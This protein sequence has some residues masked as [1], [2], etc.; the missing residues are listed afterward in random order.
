MDIRLPIPSN[1]AYKQ[2][3]F[4]KI[5]FC[6]ID[7]HTINLYVSITTQILSNKSV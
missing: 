7:Q 1:F 4:I 3:S 2:Q 6:K 5:E